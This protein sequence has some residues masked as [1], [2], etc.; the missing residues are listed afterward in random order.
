MAPFFLNIF[1]NVILMRLTPLQVMKCPK[2]T[3]TGGPLISLERTS[4]QDVLTIVWMAISTPDSPIQG[5]RVYM[6]GQMCGSQVCCSSL[7]FII[8]HYLSYGSI[9]F[10]NIPFYIRVYG[11]IFEK[12]EINT[13]KYK[14]IMLY[15]WYRNSLKLKKKWCDKLKSV[16]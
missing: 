15:R 6:N 12:Y 11:R 4:K 8:Q 10:N 7:A 16:V 5:Y 13:C 2:N 3:G 14:Y 1:L 9:A